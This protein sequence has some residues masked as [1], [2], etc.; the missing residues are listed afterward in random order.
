VASIFSDLANAYKDFVEFRTIVRQYQADGIPESAAEAKA[1]VVV[2]KDRGEHGTRQ[3]VHDQTD[4]D[5]TAH[6]F[7]GITQFVNDAENIPKRGTVQYSQFLDELWVAEPI[8][9]GAVYS[10]EAKMSSMTWKVEGGKINAAKVS[11][12]LARARYGAGHEGWSGFIGS[13]SIDFYTQDNGVFIDLT[14]ANGSEW[15]MVTDL[16]TIDTRNCILTGN[17]D[18]PM[19]YISSMVD[20][21]IWYEPGWFIHFASMPSPRELDLG[22]GTCACTRAARAAKLLLALH[23]YD[24]EKLQNL[25]PEGI[26]AVT[27]LTEREF[28]QA[29]VMWQTERKK[30]NSLTF[31]QVLWLVGNNP[32]AKIGVDISSFSQIPESYDRQTVVSQ[33]VNT[34]ALD[35]GVDTREFWAI[36]TGA[37]GTASEAEVQHLKARGKGGGEFVVLMERSLNAELPQGVQFMFDTQ[38]I[39]EDMM[40]AS[41]AKAWIDAYLPLVYPP[42]GQK[43]VLDVETFKRLLADQ[44]ALPEWAVGDDRVAIL[45]GEVHKD[46][47][48]DVVR[49]I[50]KAGRLSQ[51][52]VINMAHLCF[53]DVVVPINKAAAS[54]VIEGHAV[55]KEEPVNNIRGKPIADA[56]V[57]RGSNVT[58]KAIKAEL[59]FWKTIPQLEAHVPEDMLK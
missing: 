21:D 17:A 35:F 37:L 12:M 32:N 50:Y 34:L 11:Q 58:R 36:S 38:D 25:P 59:E 42:E 45:S 22:V 55:L 8:L 40:A 2:L 31:P 39:E 41:V 28:R 18:H 16:A 1:E 7:A 48:E 14:R 43:P 49:F 26:A 47:I 29:I 53:G 33:Y 44:R 5:V 6:I 4:I 13:S 52:Q 51:A 23:N 20:Q 15:G 10:M 24:A 46:E 3:K 54:E 57:D 56:E 30:N 19:Y 9:A 27:G